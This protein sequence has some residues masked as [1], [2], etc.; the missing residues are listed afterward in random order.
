MIEKVIPKDLNALVATADRCCAPT[1]LVPPATR[2]IGHGMLLILLVPAVSRVVAGMV[3]PDP[4][5]A[6]GGLRRLAERGLDVS[7]GVE[8]AACQALNAPFA[9]RI[10]EKVHRTFVPACLLVCFLF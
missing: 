2:G 1:R 8:A 3:D 5:T 6:G 4:R 7:V 9:H 10:W